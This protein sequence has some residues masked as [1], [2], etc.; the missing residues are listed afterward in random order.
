MEQQST[1]KLKF[2]INKM[3]FIKGNV[4]SL[5][6][7]KQNQLYAFFY[8]KQKGPIVS[9]APLMDTCDCSKATYHMAD[10]KD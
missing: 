9:V 3:I 2:G 7:Y 4:I 8:F 1:V 10:N 5:R 6:I